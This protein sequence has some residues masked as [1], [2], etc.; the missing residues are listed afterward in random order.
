MFCT[1]RL[2]RLAGLL[3]MLSVGGVS[4]ARADGLDS[5]E[6][7]VRTAKAGHAEFS[8]VVTS[9]GR[10][11]QPPRSKSSSGTFD[12]SRPNRFRF[13]YRKPMSQII[14]A[15][16]QTLW[17]FDEDLNQ[18]TARRQGAVLASTPAALI[19]SAPDI[20]AL[21]ADF[22]LRDL[23]T[24]ELAGGADASLDWILATPRSRDSSLSSIRVGFRNRNLAVLDILDS[25]GQRSVLTFGA[26]QAGGVDA[27]LFHFKPPA[28]ADVIKQ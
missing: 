22:V 8:Q 26:F 13:V 12:F 21:E 27:E 11:G 3:M 5:L 6:Q 20:K 17:L 14:V 16:G 15:D 24:K 23:T 1:T 25:F 19:A 7:F 2:G 18:V 4:F 28:G 9:P 10:D